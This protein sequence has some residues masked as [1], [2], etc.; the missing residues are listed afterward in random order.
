[1]TR[2]AIR[3]LIDDCF[4]PNAP[5][6]PA[7]HSDVI[8]QLAGRLTP[9]SATETVDLANAASRTLATDL[10][11]PFAL[12]GHTNAAV[13]GF[14]FA[15]AAYLVGAPLPVI[16]QSAAG[17]AFA[18]SVPEGSAVA[19][20]T[21]A[22]VPDGC[23]TVAMQEDCTRD[24]DSVVIPPGLKR[25]ANIRPAGED[26]AAETL[27]ARAGQRIR[28]Q[29]LAMLAATGHATL[30]CYARLSVAIASTGDELVTPGARALNRGEVYDA[31]SAMLS[32]LAASAGAA[33]QFLDRFP[34]DFATVRSALEAAAASH[35][36]IITSGGA[37]KGTADHLAD[38]LADL[39]Q[40]YH[41]QINIKPGRPVLFGQIGD[42]VVVGLPGNPVAAFVCALL[43]VWPLLRRLGGAPW[44]EPM[45]LKLPAAFAVTG[46]K[47]GRR[48]YWRGW[49]EDD[50][51]GPRA[52]KFP[53]D[54]SGLISGI[55]AANG[56]IE[57]PEEHG[58]VS[59]GDAVTFIPFA[60]YGFT[61]R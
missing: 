6:Q 5:G 47:V 43:Y 53:R 23:D 9:I 17:R 34:D 45:R 7:R 37:S 48:E 55:T 20:L 4:R 32:A 11:A 60:S 3:T 10:T 15:H 22:V 16:G 25:G 14:A 13:D 51:D 57:I 18:G 8:A 26:I 44:P 21:G 40:R 28:P 42:T 59:V 54:G 52:Q 39:G 58:D 29:D 33:P 46:R 19:I 35:D 31:N 27:I 36:V 38:A 61:D 1:M 56:L 2:D 24:R 50:E 49:I 41:W 12:P 30:S